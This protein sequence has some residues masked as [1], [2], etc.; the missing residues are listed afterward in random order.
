MGLADTLLDRRYVSRYSIEPLELHLSSGAGPRDADGTV[1]VVVSTLATPPVAV[2]T[3][4]ATRT[5]V[6]VYVLTMSSVETATPG[7]FEVSW[8]YTI[9]GIA[10]MYVGHVEVGEQSPTYDNLDDG[11][12][13]IVES[14]YIRFADLFDSPYGGPNLQ[15]YFQS[16]F[17]RERMAQL[18][19]V[20]VNRLNTIAQPHQTFSLSTAGNPFPYAQ[21]GGL[22]DH[23]LYVETIK[24]LIRSY[25][26]QPEAQGVGV[27]R[28]D[29][30]DYMNRWQSVLAVEEKDLASGL[31]VFKIANMG[32]SRPHVLVSGGVYGRFGPTRLPGTP[33]QPRFW[34]RVY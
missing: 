26:E 31:E 18:L 9:D 28:L 5:Q 21:W 1:Q 16:R 7:F 30:R 20:A 29:R 32:L 17:G 34:A 4:A 24:H 3:R 12:K 22:L 11:F 23:A 13:M 15:V 19:Q 8:T 25:V 14:A 33:A 27:A 2:I 10:Q 6:G